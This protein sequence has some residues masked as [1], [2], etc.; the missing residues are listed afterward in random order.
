[1]VGASTFGTL[2]SEWITGVAVGLA[3]IVWYAVSIYLAIKLTLLGLLSCGLIAAAA[4]EPWKLGP[5]VVESPV[6]LLTALFWVYITG[7]ASL[8]RLVGVIVALMQ[9]YAPVALLLL[10][11]TAL[12]TSPGLS[13]FGAGRALALSLDPG[14]GQADP[15]GPQIVQ[16]VFGYFAFAGLLAVEWGMVLRN[17]SDVRIGG[18]VAV[19]LAGACCAVLTPLLRRV[20]A[21]VFAAQRLH[22]DDTTVPVLAK[23]KT[24]TGR[25]W[26][27]VRDDRPFGGQGPPAGREPPVAPL[28]SPGL[29]SSKLMIPSA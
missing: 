4:L 24:D 25:L 18:W 5:L 6:F 1:V 21:H 12:W 23:G 15:G 28:L 11:V 10:G 2:G 27:Y 14:L 22:G 17:R 29:C 9:V 3:A 16:L 13:S 8:L 20:E 26:T 7:M 19:I